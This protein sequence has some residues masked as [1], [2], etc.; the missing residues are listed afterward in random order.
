MP[1]ALVTYFHH[2][3]GVSQHQV[4][5][6]EDERPMSPVCRNEH[7]VQYIGTERTPDN[8]NI[9][10]EYI[11][12]GSIASLIDKFGPLQENV[13]RVSRDE[14]MDSAGPF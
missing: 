13:V 2:E 6:P 8:L 12:G 10:L 9:F 7:I 3:R 14:W 11:A 1:V 4:L 5:L